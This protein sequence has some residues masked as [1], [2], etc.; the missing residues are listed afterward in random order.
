MVDSSK[1]F[2]SHT[3]A[4]KGGGYR[5]LNSGNQLLPARMQTVTNAIKNLMPYFGLPATVRYYNDAA[6]LS[7]LWMREF[8]FDGSTS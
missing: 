6:Q 3:C 7:N 2:P 8:V 1:L 4:L 5:S